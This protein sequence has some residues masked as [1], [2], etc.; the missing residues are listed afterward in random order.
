M[1]GDAAEPE[2]T[3]MRRRPVSIV[4]LAMPW[5]VGQSVMSD[6][7]VRARAPALRIREFETLWDVDL[8]EQLERL[9]RF[10]AKAE[11]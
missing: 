2:G 11:P 6:T 7:R 5:A 1:R 10:L 8:P 3:V 9:N 4:K